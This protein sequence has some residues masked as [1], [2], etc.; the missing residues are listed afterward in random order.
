M[1][2]HIAPA[3][4]ARIDPDSHSI[5]GSFLASRAAGHNTEAAFENCTMGCTGFVGCNRIDADTD[6]DTCFVSGTLAFTIAIP[7]DL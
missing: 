7:A 2:E 4:A 6:S 1:I 5:V 3:L